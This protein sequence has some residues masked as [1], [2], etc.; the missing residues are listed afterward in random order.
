MI[1]DRT[2]YLLYTAGGCLAYPMVLYAVTAALFSASNS[3]FVHTCGGTCTIS[4]APF[5]FFAQAGILLCCVVLFA[6][7]S[8][9]AWHDLIV[10]RREADAPGKTLTTLFRSAQLV[11]KGWFAL[12]VLAVALAVLAVGELLG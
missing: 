5:C 11:R 12:P 1:T 2:K 7:G 10:G 8:A 9:V 3:G 6:W 4:A